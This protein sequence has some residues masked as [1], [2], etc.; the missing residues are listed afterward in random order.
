[1]HSDYSDYSTY[2]NEMLL[3]I[4]HMGAKYLLADALCLRISA[5]QAEL[6]KNARTAIDLLLKRVRNGDLQSV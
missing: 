4:Y 1:M 3:H 5:D 2:S 6:I